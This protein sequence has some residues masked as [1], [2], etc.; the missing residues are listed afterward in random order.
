MQTLTTQPNTE[1]HRNTHNTAKE[2]SKLQIAQMTRVIDVSRGYAFF[3]T[4]KVIEVSFS[5]VM[6][7]NKLE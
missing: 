7:A 5:L 6:L 2:S 3:A 1:M 4:V